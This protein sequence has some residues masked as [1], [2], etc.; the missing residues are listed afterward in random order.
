MPAQVDAR[1]RFTQT[2]SWDRFADRGGDIYGDANCCLCGREL[3]NGPAR[4]IMLTRT[5]DGEW[6]AIAS[7]A[8]V[9]SDERHFDHFALP[10]GPDCLA[11][12]P[13]LVFA[14]VRSCSVC[15]GPQRR[16]VLG[17]EQATCGSPTCEATAA[18][19]MLVTPR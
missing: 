17:V 2:P 6:W 15:R 12:H 1:V 14:L 18:Q 5:N 19:R 3:L 16:V 8:P 9:Q 10:I 4:L 13:E 11:K 7:T